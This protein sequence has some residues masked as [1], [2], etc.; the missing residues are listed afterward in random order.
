MVKNGIYSFFRGLSMGKTLL[1]VEPA[2]D[3][4]I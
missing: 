3:P 4:E 2:G 1:P